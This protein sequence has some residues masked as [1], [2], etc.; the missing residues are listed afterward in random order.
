M[1]RLTDRIDLLES[2]L[3]AKFRDGAGDYGR[4]EYGKN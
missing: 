1:D 3:N 4:R 2:L